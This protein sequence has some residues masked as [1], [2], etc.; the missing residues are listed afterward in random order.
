MDKAIKLLKAVGKHFNIARHNFD[1]LKNY[2]LLS[3]LPYP[4]GRKLSALNIMQKF[5]I[6]Y[7]YQSFKGNSK[8]YLVAVP[9]QP[10]AI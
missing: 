7:R 9:L 6:V 5:N 2:M 1:E 8:I 10:V 3:N 4:S